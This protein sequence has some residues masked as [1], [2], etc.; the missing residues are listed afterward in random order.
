MGE[1]RGRGFAV[2]RGWEFGVVRGAA[3]CT[4]AAYEGCEKSMGKREPG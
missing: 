1:M 3:G 2:W 4:G